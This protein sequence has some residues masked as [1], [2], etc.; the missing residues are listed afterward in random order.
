MNG[1]ESKKSGS[2]VIQ[3]VEVLVMGADSSRQPPQAFYRIEVGRVWR[4]EQGAESSR[5]FYRQFAGCA[6]M[7][8]CVIDNKEDALPVLSMLRHEGIEESLKGLAVERVRGVHEQFAGC[9]VHRPK[10]T[11][12]LASRFRQDFRLLSFERPHARYGRRELEVDLI[13]KPDLNARV[14]K[15]VLQFF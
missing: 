13:L 10:I 6:L 12:L 3:P 2:Q 4:Q 11:D 9:G 14:V 5:L 7:P 15:R 8:A 1:K